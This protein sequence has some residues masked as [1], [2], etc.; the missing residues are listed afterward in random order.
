MTT[1]EGVCV[2][3]FVLSLDTRLYRFIEDDIKK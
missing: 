2:G 3:Y 1:T